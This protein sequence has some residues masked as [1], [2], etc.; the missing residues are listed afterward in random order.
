MRVRSEEVQREKLSKW[1][2]RLALAAFFPALGIAAGVAGLIL[3]ALGLY[4]GK[5]YPERFGGLWKLR[6]AVVLCILSLLLSFFELDAFFRLK[7]RQAEQARYEITMMRL[8]ELAEIMESY[9]SKSGQYPPGKTAEEVGKIV[10]REGVTFFPEIDG[11]GRPL[12]LNSEPWDYTIAADNPPKDPMKT[13]PVLKAQSPMPVFPFVGIYPG[14]VI[15]PQPP[16]PEA[17][18]QEAASDPQAQPVLSDS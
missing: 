13:F 11:W 8:Y 2:F 1:C 15:E 7:S 9:A 17:P 16:V 3:S 6:A 12:K 14:T 18:Q 10:A 5:K 4:L